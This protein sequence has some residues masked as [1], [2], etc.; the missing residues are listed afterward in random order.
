MPEQKT[1]AWWAEKPERLTQA[2]LPEFWQ[3][4]GTDERTAQGLAE[5]G[6]NLSSLGAISDPEV[7]KNTLYQKVLELKKAGD[8]MAEGFLNTYGSD[9]GV[10]NRFLSG[11][12]RGAVEG[13]ATPFVAEKLGIDRGLNSGELL[14]ANNVGNVLGNL[15][16]FMLP[17]GLLLKGATK[18]LP[19]VAALGAHGLGQG[20]GSHDMFERDKKGVREM[21]TAE[22]QDIPPELA[23]SSRDS[24]PAV[25]NMLVQGGLSAGSAG[26][27]GKVAQKMAVGQPISR[28]LSRT[29]RTFPLVEGVGSGAAML[30]DASGGNLGALD[31]QAVAAA[32]GAP[33]AMGTWASH[34]VGKQISGYQPSP[35]GSKQGGQ[36]SPTDPTVGTPSSAL[37]EVLAGGRPAPQFPD[38][39]LNPDMA[40]SLVGQLGVENLD[41]QLGALLELTRGGAP[42]HPAGA[43]F[44]V[45]HPEQQFESKL[46]SILPAE[47]MR[48]QGLSS[49]D[50][51]RYMGQMSSGGIRPMQEGRIRDPKA[52][53]QMGFSLGGQRF[54]APAHTYEPVM[55]DFPV[56]LGGGR[57]G[58]A[59][60]R[61]IG[62]EGEEKFWYVAAQ[63]PDGSWVPMK[64]PAGGVQP[65]RDPAKP[66]NPHKM[67]PPVPLQPT[68]DV[69]V[70]PDA[71]MRALEQLL[72][73]LRLSAPG[74]TQAQAPRPVP[75][76]QQPR[77]PLLDDDMPEWLPRP[78][79]AGRR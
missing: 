22:G 53:Y 49:I 27:A 43:E 11:F 37:P 18:V 1:I 31:G 52:G 6:K 73:K 48:E 74:Q 10:V 32:L 65:L 40:R 38:A 9:T 55:D 30:L 79:V 72:A 7:R 4:M 41:R 25:T 51:P 39:Q 21:L 69:Q 54:D 24:L 13:L 28:E 66:M 12:G 29:A 45:S 3:G 46:L 34:Q 42:K 56:D 63:E 62:A 58:K 64:V 59:I 36:P 2:S 71:Q 57:Q 60:L 47:D 78:M 33:A 20:L 5:W 17:G 19:K 50:Y 61:P 44:F 75:S 67:Q 76:H 14:D 68:R 70:D 77:L 35:V 23:P 15:A 16:G 26:L 8:P